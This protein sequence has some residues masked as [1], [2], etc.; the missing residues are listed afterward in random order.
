M[1][2]TQLLKYASAIAITII[3]FA[4]GSDEQ[5]NLEPSK[6]LTIKS[7]S[8]KSAFAGTLVTV[9]GT[10]LENL[11]SVKLGKIKLNLILTTDSLFTFT[12]PA[13]AVS[14]KLYVYKGN[15]VDSS[16]SVIVKTFKITGISPTIATL[17]ETVTVTGTMLNDLDSV[18]FGPEKL[19]LDFERNNTYFTFLTRFNHFTDKLYIYKDGYIDSSLTL[20]IVEPTGTV[21]ARDGMISCL[22]GNFTYS[23]FAGSS[24][25][26]YNGNQ[27]NLIGSGTLFTDDDV[28]ILLPRNLEVNKTYQATRNT[29]FFYLNSRFGGED[30][31][32]NGSNGTSGS[33]TVTEL[34]SNNSYLRGTFNFKG[35]ANNGKMIKVTRGRVATILY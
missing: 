13:S 31:T 9:A 15:L 35:L 22:I 11:D 27:V 19:I 2:I 17:D 33:F 25:D 12:I 10:Y 8:P 21:T 4:C 34:G 14:G 3:A 30:F 28:T 18:K 6:T 26:T 29:P 5:T 7:I 32:A 24:L 1:K 20:S 23:D 16:Q